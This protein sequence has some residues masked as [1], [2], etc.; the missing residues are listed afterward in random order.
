MPVTIERVET[1]ALR[2]P[3]DHWAPK[4]TFGGI[5]RDTMDC[6]LIR[7]HRDVNIGIHK[8]LRSG[9][10]LRCDADDGKDQA[11][12]AN[13]S[14]KDRTVARELAIPHV[15]TDDRHQIPARD[16][17]FIGAEPAPE[18]RLDAQSAEEI[19]ADAG[20]EAVLRNLVHLSGDSGQKEVVT[21]ESL[22]RFCA[23]A[24]IDVIGIGHAPQPGVRRG[25][26]DLDNP[27]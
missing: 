1:V 27:A 18:H 3:Y 21:R 8:R 12:H 19:P 4:P 13:C 20:V 16:A 24:E 17:V 22:E 10:I 25:R 5:A 11:V 14:S 26:V 9:K 15:M 6:L 23:I 7:V 2:I